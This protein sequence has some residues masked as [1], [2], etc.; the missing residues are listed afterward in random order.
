MSERNVPASVRA[1]LLNHARETNQEFNH[2]LTRY[3][4][5]RMLYRIGISARTPEASPRHQ[6]VLKFLFN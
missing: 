2:V 6:N 3:A 1:R 5:E 4:I